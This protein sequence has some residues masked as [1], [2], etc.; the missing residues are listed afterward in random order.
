MNTKEKIGNNFPTALNTSSASKTK[1]IGANPLLTA[2]IQEDNIGETENSAK[3]F[4]STLNGLL[5]LFAMGGAIRSRSKDE[6]IQL[7]IKA[8]TEDQLLAMKLLF[9]LRN[10]RGGAGERKT[11]RI[12][13][14]WLGQNY[15]DVAGKNIPNIAQFG[16]FD[17][18]YCLLGTN[19]EKALIQF[20]QTQL[21][22]DCQNY[23]QNKPISL[24]AKWLKSENT[25]SLESKRIATYI[26]KQLGW[27]SKQYRKTLSTLRQYT[28]VVEQKMS[29]N[30]W[31]KINYEKVPSKAN[32]T[33]RNAFK[34]HDAERY[35]EFI[36]A[37]K[38]GQKKINASALFPYEII[39]KVVS[40]ADE[41]TMDVLWDALPNYME[42]TS[43]N[44]LTVA[45]M[46][47]SMT[48][49][50][51]RPMNMAL[52]LAIYTAE[53]NKGPFANFF[54]TFSEQPTLQQVIGNTIREK[55][56]SI[57][58]HAHVNTNLQKVFQML[59]ASAIG[60]KIKQEDMP[61]QVLVVTDMEFD[62]P[63]D[64]TKT[65]LEGVE[66]MYFNAG[67]KMP[68][69]VF[70]NVASRQNNVPVAANKQGV[71]LVSGA[72]PSVFKTLLS[73][74]Q[75]TPIDQMLETLNQEMYNCVTI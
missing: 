30:D 36:E 72:S 67:Y 24:L 16:R 55:I 74:K 35:Q 61:E 33:Y 2:L 54:I 10:I 34:K 6:I 18:L 20:I 65:N 21:D 39:E 37:V 52:A 68:Q 17:D 44:I 49:Q 27:T 70:W 26:R 45:D 8:F 22:S 7:F 25:S 41:A 28:N 15:S 43:R 42:D 63:F 58:A 32:L 73:G 50:G 29:A 75:H 66:E 51:G 46:S 60:N 56:L 12:I 3:T 4:K 47:G 62:A 64:T 40:G 57:K 19:S 14:Q 23:E 69:L 31:G 48:T 53:H 1:R 13:L 71:L 11:F 5:D 38:K 59:L 9:H